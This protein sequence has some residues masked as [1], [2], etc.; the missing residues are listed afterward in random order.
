M[1]R[2]VTQLRTWGNAEGRNLAL[3]IRTNAARGKVG[4]RDQVEI[5]RRSV[6]AEQVRKPRADKIVE[7]VSQPPDDSP[8]GLTG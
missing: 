2:T 1:A 3:F 7:Y 4:H 6:L 8:L 5:V